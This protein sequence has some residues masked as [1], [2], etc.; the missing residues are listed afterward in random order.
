VTLQRDA[1][2]FPCTPGR[3][4]LLPVQRLRGKTDAT[5][6]VHRG[7][8]ELQQYA[9]SGKLTKDNYD[10]VGGLKGLIEDAA[11]RALRGLEHQSRM[12]RCRLLYRPSGLSLARRPLCRHSFK[13]AR[14]CSRP[15]SPLLLRPFCIAL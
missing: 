11:E 9:A 10:K 7:A 12:C 4:S 13:S 5:T 3:G 15:S 14:R 1:T 6:G 2:P 8:R